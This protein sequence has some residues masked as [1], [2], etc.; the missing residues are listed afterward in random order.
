M[1]KLN[2]EQRRKITSETTFKKWTIEKTSLLYYFLE[3]CE[4]IILHPRLWTCLRIAIEFVTECKVD[5]NKI[6][7]V[8]KFPGQ[9]KLEYPYVLSIFFNQLVKNNVDT[10]GIN[11]VDI[12]MIQKSISL[13]TSS[14]LLL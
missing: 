4:E 10:T 3:E 12:D 7:P 13:I 11:K 1:M 5:E 9:W 8:Y 2:D 6:L 14:L